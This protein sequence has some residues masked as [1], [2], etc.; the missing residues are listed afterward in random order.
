MA[1]AKGL[2]YK[3]A[4]N[5]VPYPTPDEF[6]IVHRDGVFFVGT[7]SNLCDLIQDALDLLEQ[8]DPQEAQVDEEKYNEEEIYVDACNCGWCPEIE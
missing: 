2:L 3:R 7:M 4:G 5:T 1:Y 8:V 6:E